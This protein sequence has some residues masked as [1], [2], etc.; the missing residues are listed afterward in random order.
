MGSCN[1]GAW[2]GFVAHDLVVSSDV[3][4]SYGR[5]MANKTTCADNSA[6]ASSYVVEPYGGFSPLGV[7][8]AGGLFR[9]SARMVAQRPMVGI[10]NRRIRG[11]PVAGRLALPEIRQGSHGRD[12]AKQSL[13]EHGKHRI[14]V[15]HH[16]EQE[17]ALI[18]ESQWP[19]SSPTWGADGRTLIFG[20]FSPDQDVTATSSVRGRYE[21][22]VQS[23]LDQ[24]RVILMQ[25][26]LELDAEQLASISMLKPAVSSDS[27]YVAV[28]RPGKTPGLWVIRLDQ[29]RVIK[30]IDSAR[31]PAWAPDGLRLLFLKEAAGPLG[32][33]IRSIALLN[34][35]MGPERPVNT[36]VT[37]LDAPPLW[38]LDG[39]S[40]LAIA[41]PRAAKCAMLRWTLSGS[42][43]TRVSGFDCCRWRRLLR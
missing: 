37:L 33:P 23:G 8:D 9:R 24:K 7:L 35:D 29:D 6:G 1:A 13:N 14:W 12:A 40:I 38:S 10:H 3:Q 39:Q 41:H 27:R 11:L 15:T 28:P 22:V 43:S 19:L 5:S 4:T 20:R 25:A 2:V 21:I 18:E 42:A 34:H 17:S 32:G 36:D 31:Y 30:S 26:D 16:G